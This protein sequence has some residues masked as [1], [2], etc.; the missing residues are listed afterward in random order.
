[1]S[2]LA[3]EQVPKDTGGPPSILKARRK[4]KGKKGKKGRAQT[5]PLPQ[6]FIREETVAED[7]SGGED[8]GKHR[9]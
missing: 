2:P 1:M 8:S 5:A 6:V 7:L 3:S 9:R 4:Q